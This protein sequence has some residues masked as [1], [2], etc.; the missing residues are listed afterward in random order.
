MSTIHIPF[1]PSRRDFVRLTAASAAALAS[2]GL[3]LLTACSSDEILAPPPGATL[4]SQGTTRNP[5]RIPSTI[6]P[7]GSSLTARAASSDLGGGQLSSVLSYNGLFPGPTVVAARGNS[8]SIPFTNQLSEQSSIHWHGMI[9]PTSADGQ[10]KDAVQPGGS[11]TYSFTI[12]QRAC[13]NWYHP[14]PHMLTGKQV[15]LGLAGAFIVRMWEIGRESCR[16]RV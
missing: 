10:P 15:C 12:N 3:S 16:D 11:R 2:G 6:G 4:A 9:V 1:Q 13:L 8:V 5:L 7:S 14:H